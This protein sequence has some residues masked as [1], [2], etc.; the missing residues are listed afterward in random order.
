MDEVEGTREVGRA[1][2]DVDPVAR[3]VVPRPTATNGEPKPGLEGG[4]IGSRHER[5]T[6]VGDHRDRV[7]CRSGG[8]YRGQPVPLASSEERLPDGTRVG[9]PRESKVDRPE[10]PPVR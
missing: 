4:C 7:R 9:D 5:G 2:P 8:R 1:T 3:V 10:S 6:V